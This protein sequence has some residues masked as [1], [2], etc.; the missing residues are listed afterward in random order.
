M[1]PCSK[2]QKEDKRLF[3]AERRVKEDIAIIDDYA[4]AEVN[5]LG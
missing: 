5:M 4:R 1:S 2:V 3:D